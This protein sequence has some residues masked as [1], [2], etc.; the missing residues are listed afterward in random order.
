MRHGAARRKACRS[1]GAAQVRWKCS[2]G[3]WLP[4]LLMLGG[5][6][7]PVG[8]R[9]RQSVNDARLRAAWSRAA[10]AGPSSGAWSIGRVI[11]GGPCLI[12][13]SIGGSPLLCASSLGTSRCCDRSCIHLHMGSSA[14]SVCPCRV[15]FALKG[16]SAG[17]S[18][19]RRQGAGCWQEVLRIQTPLCTLRV[20]GVLQSGRPAGLQKPRG[21]GRGPVPQ[22]LQ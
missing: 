21:R 2:R 17:G 7:H 12:G 6:P 10:Q 15:R 1:C 13:L 22:P 9:V 4:H 18:G 16:L 11:P 3:P 14:F 19:A 8:A 5:P 20:S